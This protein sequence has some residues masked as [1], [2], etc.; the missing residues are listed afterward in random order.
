MG[1]IFSNSWFLLP[2]YIC[3][4]KF[5]LYVEKA[6]SWRD[7]AEK[8]DESE[9]RPSLLVFQLIVELYL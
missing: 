3:I 4:Y 5:M 7:S 9:S 1:S 2:D 8:V 6:G